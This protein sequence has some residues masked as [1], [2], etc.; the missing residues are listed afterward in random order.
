MGKRLKRYNHAKT[1][2]RYHLIFSTKY[3]KKCLTGMETCLSNSIERAQD[4]AEFRVIEHGIDRDHM[5]FLVEMGHSCTV[6]DTVKRLKQY[7]TYWAWQEE[8]EH[9]QKYY[10]KGQH[11]LWTRGYYA[12]T[13]GVEED[14]IQKYVQAQV[15]K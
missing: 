13:V 6:S 11:H 5:H 8:R 10:W 9:L 3:R 2:L 4:E 12:A 14:C 7:T 1:Y 15:S